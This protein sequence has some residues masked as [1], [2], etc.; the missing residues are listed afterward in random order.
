M[1]T[2]R[3][4]RPLTCV[5]AAAALAAV[6]LVATAPQPARAQDSS[7]QAP[8]QADAAAIGAG[9]WCSRLPPG[10]GHPPA[11]LTPLS[12]QV[13]QRS[14]EPVPATDG[15]IHLAY[16][17]QATNTQ[18]TPATIVGVVPV[19]PIAG[20]VPT[21]TNLITDEQGRSVAGKVKLF[22]TS[23][24]ST[25][26]DDGPEMEPPTAFSASVPAGNSGLMFFDVTYTDPAQIPRLLSHAITLAA[27]DGGP[28]VAGLTNPVPV[29]CRALAVVH[30][31]LVGQG[32]TAFNACCTYA[33]YHRT[34]VPPVNGLLQAG[35]QFAI[36]YIQIGPDNTCCHGP[37]AAVTSWYGYGTPVLAAAPGVVVE[38][39]NGMPDQEPVGTITPLPPARITGNS[40][41]EYIGAGQYALYAHLKPGTIPVSIRQGARLRTG[42]LIGRVGNSGN[43]G[44]PHLHFQ[45]MDNSSFADA[46]GLPFV[47][48]TQVL[49]GRV[50]EVAIDELVK[51]LAVTI[52]RTGTGRRL[53]LM[54]ARNG[55][56][57]YNLSQ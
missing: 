6:G 13:L 32:W 2:L 31:P 19:D 24:D 34:A 8:P 54:P 10:Y 56:F 1:T 45:L 28:G 12:L 37:V 23:P 44:A 38:V 51:G 42:D 48:D 47:F 55:V 4:R 17:A 39:T 11:N 20:F 52:D 46:T 53:S 7:A 33:A 30:P 41:I 26:P 16:V 36:D 5:L 57:G 43:S 50:S 15:L 21:G 27:P 35:Q 9:N 49:E 25:L 40:I 18:A 3:M 29:G 22:V 14:I